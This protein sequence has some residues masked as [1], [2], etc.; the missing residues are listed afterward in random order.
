MNRYLKIETYFVFLRAINNPYKKLIAILIPKNRIHNPLLK[1]TSAT[2]FKSKVKISLQLFINKEIIVT[3]I[4]NGTT[5]LSKFVKK[6]GDFIFSKSVII[7]IFYC[8][9]V[10]RDHVLFLSLIF[11]QKP[12]V[13]LLLSDLPNTTP[14]ITHLPILLLSL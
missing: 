8:C 3:R 1:L 11:Y 7:V 9:D 10:Y 12:F 2:L 14:Q 13:N 4:K 6:P 5:T